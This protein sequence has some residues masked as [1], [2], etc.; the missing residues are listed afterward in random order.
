MG[1]RPCE[2]CDPQF[3][4]EAG[5]LGPQSPSRRRSVRAGAFAVDFPPETER[6]HVVLECRGPKLQAGVVLRPRVP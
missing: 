1:R 3:T 4:G 5:G 6:G 2:A